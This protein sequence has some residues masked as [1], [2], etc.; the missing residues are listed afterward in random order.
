MIMVKYVRI[1]RERVG[2][3]R[4][5]YHIRIDTEVY[6]IVGSDLGTSHLH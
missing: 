5:K 1:K 3:S 4:Q 6:L 2:Q